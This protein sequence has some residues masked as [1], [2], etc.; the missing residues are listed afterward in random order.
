MKRKVF[1]SHRSVDYDRFAKRIISKL[2]EYG[3]ETWYSEECI[4]DG[5]DY[6]TEIVNAISSCDI[7]LAIITDEVLRQPGQV[8][9]ELS[10]A[11]SFGKIK[12]AIVETTKPIPINMLYHF[13]R[14]T[15]R[16]YE[17][18]E[19]TAFLTLFNLLGVIY[20]KSTLNEETASTA[21]QV[22]AAFEMNTDR[23]FD[24]VNGKGGYSWGMNKSVIQN[25][26]GGWPLK[27]IKVENWDN[28]LFEFKCT[29]HIS[30]YQEYL[31][32]Q[33]C[34]II[35]RK[36][37]NH[38]RWMLV[39]YDAAYDNLFLSLQRTEWK[40]TQFVWHHLLRDEA[41]RKN[42]VTAFFEEELSDY[43][44]SLCL[45]L[46]LVDNENNIV[47]SRIKKRKKDDYPGTIAI[48]IGEQLDETDYTSS[49]DNFV[50]QWMRRSLWEEFRLDDDKIPQYVDESSA[51]IMALDL[52]GDI[53]NF[54]LVCCVRL[55]STTKQLYDFYQINR[56]SEDE[57]DELFPI[58][59]DEVP[60]ILR[61]SNQLRNEYH[62]SSF[63]R[64]L[65]AYLYIRKHLPIG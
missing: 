30:A 28:R 14:N 16:W 19:E 2:N 20:H 24:A 50:L 10:L 52:E 41:D 32:S 33:E 36:G 44:N 65:Y 55:R 13:Q 18:D 5:E 31:T 38:T 27:N 42:A 60:N 43:P 21:Q 34:E 61:N 3:I 11:S 26:P 39:G 51:R 40:Q 59:L 35:M 64:L 54:A 63:I 6:A 4:S 45:H 25:I 58:S 12:L 15:I 8:L 56:S 17:L 29:K 48:T 53:Y 7:F 37:K 1:I 46:I 23:V 47:A 22:S 62:P 57:F 49:S 9:N